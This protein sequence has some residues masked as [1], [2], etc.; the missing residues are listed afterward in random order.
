MGT[1]QENLE[2]RGSNSYI[3][4][5]GKTFQISYTANEDQFQPESPQ[6]LSAIPL[7]IKLI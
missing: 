4:N 1:D 7:K 6:Y 3:D 2:A 5:D